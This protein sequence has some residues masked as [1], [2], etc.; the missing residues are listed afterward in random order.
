[1]DGIRYYSPMERTV[2]TK[3]QVPHKE[4]AGATYFVTFRLG[5]SLLAAL[6]ANWARERDAWLKANPPP[7]GGEL[8]AEYHRRFTARIE[9]WLDAGHGKCVLRNAAAAKVVAD[10][11]IHFEGSRCRQF[12]FVVMPNHVH[13]LFGLIG[14]TSL[15]EL[16]KSWKGFTSRVLGLQWPGQWPGWQRSY[17]DR[18]IRNENHFSRCARYIRRNPEKARLRAGGFAAFESEMART[19]AGADE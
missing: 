9:G 5:D 13:A 10:A 7:H 18:L 1:M 3:N 16:V 15:D 14:E 17:F 11:L 19:I 2:V 4:Q 8:E 6:L 12:S